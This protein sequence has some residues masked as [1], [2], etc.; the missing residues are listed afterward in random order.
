MKNIVSKLILP[1]IAMLSLTTTQAVADSYLVIAKGAGSKS[2]EKVV[3]QVN[4]LGAKITD[5]IEEAGVVVIDADANDIS[6]IADVLAVIPNVK[7]Q[8]TKPSERIAVQAANPPN[9]G[10]DDFF[11]DRQWG[12]DAV[13]APEAWKA[14]VKGK[15]ARVAVLD[16]GFSI[17][18]PDIADNV[19]DYADMT[20]EGIAYAPNDDDPSGI[21]SHGMHVAGTI[22]AADNGY[23]VI[24]VAPEAELLLVKVLGNIGSGSFADVL[25]GI[26]FATNYGDVDIINMS[27]GAD[28]PQGLG[29]G[30]DGV[31][32][33]RVAF[34][35]VFSYAYSNGISIFVSAGND[36]RDLDTDKSMVVF[37]AD[38]AHAISISATGPEGWGADPSTNLDTQAVYT[39][40]G[41]SSI[42]FSAPGGDYELLFS[43]PALG[44][45]PCTVAGATRPCYVWDFVF[46]SGSDVGG[47]WYYWSV[48]TSMA[49]PHAAGVAA[50]IVSENGGSMH[51]AKLKAEMQKRADDLAQPGKDKVHGMGRVSSGY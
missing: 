38:M 16:G 50:L 44:F 34:N 37:P 15:G 45:S 4:K 19:I 26:I 27:L 6:A 36:G 14:G 29:I 39:N 5:V 40:Y 28:I 35:R 24:G 23:G 1:T 12:H 25:N 43:N 2:T 21:F 51:P 42:D 8:M 10:D 18:H 48:G 7:I 46:S 33:L 9:S 13:N 11:F 30:S 41:R 31:A 32:A 17:N 47:I 49:A 20:G 3:K 22:A